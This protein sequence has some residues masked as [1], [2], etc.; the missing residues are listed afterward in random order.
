MM[1]VSIIRSSR[2]AM[3]CIQASRCAFIAWVSDGPLDQ[4][5]IGG[6]RE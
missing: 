3:V 1:P 5:A 4:P 2:R 6:E